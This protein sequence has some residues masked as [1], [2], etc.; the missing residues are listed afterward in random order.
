MEHAL[1]T[2]GTYKEDKSN[3]DNRAYGE[4]QTDG[5][6]IGKNGGSMKEWRPEEVAPTGDQ[7]DLE[8]GGGEGGG[9]VIHAEK[10]REGGGGGQGADDM[11][12]NGSRSGATKRGSDTTRG[13]N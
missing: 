1:P 10:E 7:E 6:V 5:P 11:A 12:N 9:D 3:G 4:T 8:G 13:V 2:V